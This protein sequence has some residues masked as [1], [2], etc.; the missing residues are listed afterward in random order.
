MSGQRG[1]A[2]RR[3]ATRFSI[4]EWMRVVDFSTGVAGGY[5]AKLLSDAGADV[6][7]VES[8]GGDP[9]RTRSVEPSSPRT[10][11]GALFRFLHAGQRSVVGTPGD[12]LVEGL[13]ARADVILDTDR[14]PA[15]T[16]L[17][18]SERHPHLC[19]VSIT[20][21]GR[22]GPWAGRPATEFTMQ[23]A[24]GSTGSRGTLDREPIAIGGGLGEWI[25]GAYAA[26]VTLSIAR[27]SRAGGAGE[28]VD[29]SIFECMAIAMGGYG[30]LKSGLGGTGWPVG[31]RTIELPSI[32]STAEGKYVCFTTNS[33][34]QFES[35]LVLIDRADWLN[36]EELKTRDGRDRRRAEFSRAV[37]D[38][39]TGHSAEEI[40]DL[41]S[42]L[43]IPVAVVSTPD[44]ITAVEQLVH[45]GVFVDD[46]SDSFVQPRIPYQIAGA[47]EVP[48][49]RPPLLGEHSRDE[50]WSDGASRAASGAARLPL[51]G[52]RVVDLTTWWAGPMVAQVLGLLGADVVKVESISHPDGCR[53]SNVARGPEHDQ[54]WE[55]A[56]LFL[57]ANVNKRGVTLD[58]NC[59]DGKLLFLD[60]VAG[61]DL[62]I[63]NFTPRVLDNFGLTPE[64]MLA[65]NPQV[66]VVRMP[67]FGLD[68][69]W[70]DRPG[71]AQTMESVSGMAWLTGFADGPPVLP[72]G[73]CD[74]NAGLHTA[75]AALVGLEARD[76]KG[77]GL[78][79]ETPMIESALNLAAEILVE[80]GAGGQSVTRTGNRTRGVVP[81]GVYRCR[82][83]ERWV[84]LS[85]VTDE[86]W[87]G[88]VVAMGR[89]EWATAADLGTVRGRMAS[90]DTIDDRLR[91]WLAGLEAEEA[92]EILIAAGVP[93]EIVSGVEHLGSNPQLRARH[94]IE[95]FDHPLLGSQET[96]GAPFRF[97]SRREPWIRSPAPTLGQHN[98]EVLGM[99]L[100]LS[101]SALE[102]LA[103]RKVIGDRPI[104][105]PG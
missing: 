92:V 21:F 95:T 38:W 12:P 91:P 26:V 79:V 6:V 86:H 39:T 58:L 46:P 28:H 69:P 44:A 66:V 53:F 47:S 20:P 18:W 90:Q 99:D 100:G 15:D 83:D 32:E 56:F 93:A 82:G 13:V 103:W 74:P 63:E 85:V 75:F 16:L 97:A 105:W 54:W 42:A 27:A 17:E 88:L 43:R 76:A 65:R 48:V 14:I 33:R 68:G 45:R 51:E 60:L 11:D 104:G 77:G 4:L 7:K 80:R 73:I 94:F 9:L 49:T 23:A 70:R 57:S 64:L 55:T 5:C 29:L 10:G 50:L 40:V 1:A 71:F 30:V 98:P 52:V 3:S 24:C 84:A 2:G 25:A 101:A 59:E 81:Q 72:R 41:A 37:G 78:L 87:S 62:V 96:L 22:T 102:G 19:V 35:F 61:A 36:D 8:A 67:A 31:P 89:P 34:E